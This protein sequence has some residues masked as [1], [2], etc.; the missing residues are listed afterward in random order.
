[1]RAFLRQRLGIAATARAA[2]LDDA[3]PLELDALTRWSV[4]ERLLAARLVG[5]E[6]D[7]AVAAERARGTL[8]P[9]KI[10]AKTVDKLKPELDAILAAA[11]DT[12]IGGTAMTVDVRVTLP[13]GRV[14][15]GTVPGVVADVLQTVAFARV[16]AAHRLGA[17]VRLLALTA[18]D[19]ERP[20]TA[21]TVGRARRGAGQSASVTVA[22]IPL[23]GGASGTAE[24][25]RAF[26]VEHLEGLVALYDQGMT[27]PLPVYTETSAAYASGHPNAAANAA[28]RW[29]VS[30]DRDG[31]RHRGENEREEHVRVFG[32]AVPF[33]DLLDERPRVD[34]TGEGWD[35]G[36]TTRFGRYAR[37]W[38]RD[39][40]RRERVTDR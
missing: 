5:I 29:Q 27:E 1:V 26:A 17:W 32:T 9:G 35:E 19:P 2:E 39:L 14:L 13:G 37:R 28:E 18:T 22:R 8:P 12:E 7:D 24:R 23:L 3:L 33:A 11:D 25:R 21:V 4:G 38:W 34:E 30:W 16:S 40:P 10:G 31:T 6:F 20:F 15:N 36:E